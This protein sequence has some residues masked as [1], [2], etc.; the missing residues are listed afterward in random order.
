MSAISVP[1]PE[2]TQVQLTGPLD[3]VGRLMTLL[4]SEAE[5]IFGP[6]MEPALGGD[7]SCVARVVTRPVP[8]TP[9][10]GQ[11]VSVTVQTVLEANTDAMPGLPDAAA[12]QQVEE[13]VTAA[14][15]GLPGVQQVS[16]RMVAAVGLPSRE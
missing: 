14:L 7:V 15:A 5:V 13:S 12:A 10:A 9:S 1:D 16:S 6:V 2:F 4:G 11:T 3:A 8:R